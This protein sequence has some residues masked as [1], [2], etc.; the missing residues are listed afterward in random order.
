VLLAGGRRGGMLLKNEIEIL[1]D[2]Y[3]I[4]SALTMIKEEEP[5]WLV[6]IREIYDRADC[7]NQVILRANPGRQ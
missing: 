3:T 4:S 6:V 1:V 7:A 2:I 5:S